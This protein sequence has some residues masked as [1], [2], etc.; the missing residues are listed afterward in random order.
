MPWLLKLRGDSTAPIA[1]EYECPVHGRFTVTVP[2]PEPD[3]QPCAVELNP[4][5]AGAIRHP[6]GRP[7][8]WR[9]PTPLGRVKLGELA[10]GKS[11]P[12]PPGSVMLDTR[13]LA[14]GMPYS[15]WKKGQDAITRDLNLKWHRARRR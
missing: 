13:P 4:D 1:A 10:K 9:F 15:E 14:D 3:E 12:R 5:P 11:D 6:C 8:P 7:S 2:R